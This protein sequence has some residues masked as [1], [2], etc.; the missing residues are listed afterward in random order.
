MIETALQSGPGFATKLLL[1]LQ[2]VPV[3]AE[4]VRKARGFDVLVVIWILSLELRTVPVS[5]MG[6]FPTEDV[7]VNSVRLPLFRCRLY[8]RRCCRRDYL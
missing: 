6:A 4:L 7:P 2:A 3:A 1:P 8:L 5:T